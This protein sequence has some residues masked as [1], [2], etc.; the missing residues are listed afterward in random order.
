MKRQFISE[1]ETFQISC[2]DFRSSCN[3][4]SM[5]K[6]NADEPLKIENGFLIL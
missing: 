2:G 6:P 5:P 3:G 4:R 1:P